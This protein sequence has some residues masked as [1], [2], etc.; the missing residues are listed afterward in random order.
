MKSGA[1]PVNPRATPVEP[2]TA[3][4]ELREAPVEPVAAPV[5]PVVA[6][7]DKGSSPSEAT[8]TLPGS[9]QHYHTLWRPGT[10]NKRLF[11]CSINGL[12]YV[13]K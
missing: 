13:P 9:N 7:V 4:M 5:E 8:G 2:G 11:I 12:S 6:L 1:T 10:S 3:A